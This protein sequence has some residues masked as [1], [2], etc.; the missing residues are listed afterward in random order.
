[1]ARSK[2]NV[3]GGWAICAGHGGAIWTGHGGGEGG[4]RLQYLQKN[5]QYLKHTLYN[6]P[7]KRQNF[8]LSSKKL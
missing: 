3:L 7:N 1:M 4:N 5:K 2:N 8:V 6:R